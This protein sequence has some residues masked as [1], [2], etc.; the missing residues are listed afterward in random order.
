MEQLRREDDARIL[1]D[2]NTSNVLL[3]FVEKHPSR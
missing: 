3:I 2:G 1:K